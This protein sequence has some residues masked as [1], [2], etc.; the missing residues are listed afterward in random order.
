MKNYFK[1]LSFKSLALALMLIWPAIGHSIP[2][3]SDSSQIKYT[4]DSLLIVPSY[5]QE[6]DSVSLFVA[7]T[8]FSGGCG[9]K[10]SKVQVV[11]NVINVTANYKSGRLTQICHST[12][13][14]NL[15][16]FKS[17][18]YKVVFNKMNTIEFF[19][20]KKDSQPSCN[21]AFTFSFPKCKSK[22]CG[23]N[24]VKF[25]DT[26]TGKAI[27][28]LWSFGDS[29]YSHEQNPIHYY[30]SAGTYNVTLKIKTKKGCITETWQTL[31][32]GMPA[33]K[34][35]FYSIVSTCN[36]SSI[37]NNGDSIVPCN[38]NMVKF[39][40]TSFG[41]VTKC[42]WN[43]GDGTTSNEYSPIHTYPKT[44]QYWPV[45]LT[46]FTADSCSSIH[47]DS[48]VFAQSTCNANF[49]YN[50]YKDSSLNAENNVQFTDLSKGEA[51]SWHWS[52]G[53]ST[54][55]T[56]QHPSH[57]F[58][59]PGSYN[60]CLTIN[61]I[62]G[63]NSTN[64]QTLNVG[65]NPAKCFAGFYSYKLSCNDS[66]S[67]GSDSSRICGDN[68]MQFINTSSSN[69]TYSIWNFGD[70][71]FSYEMNPIHK[72]S[73]NQKVWP[74]S[75]TIYT[76]DSC[77]SFYMD[78]VIFHSECKAAFYYVIP[79]CQDSSNCIDKT[80]FFYDISDANTT[81]WQWDLGDNI[82]SN[83]QNPSHIYEKPG[84]YMVNLKIQTLNGCSS[85]TWQSINV[86]FIDSSK[87]FAN[88][89]ILTDS[90]PC[91]KCNGCTCIQLQNQ[92]SFNAISWFWKFG[93]GDSSFLPNPTHMYIQNSMDSD[94][95]ISLIIKTNSGC[96]AEMTKHINYSQ[97]SKSSLSIG[98]KELSSLITI[99]PN[100][101]INEVTLSLPSIDEGNAILKVA[102]LS[103]IVVDVQNYNLSENYNNKLRYNV[104]QLRNGHYIC[105]I[106]TK[107]SVFK[108]KFIVN[109]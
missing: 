107:K 30:Q 15:G 76:S 29:S 91:P 51:I 109:K 68:V 62:S 106:I 26:S 4:I 108:G 24:A 84:I 102:D 90:L 7:T 23:D 42:I 16:E 69:V 72:F 86:G 11:K 101:A 61:T 3:P 70:G 2:K 17:G 55:S 38:A 105:C 18:K 14:I 34:A 41:D 83:E 74:V 47:Y 53:D 54:F 96:S 46:I 66:I 80:V 19:V 8:H 52:F 87:C 63:C 95:M 88:F 32:V 103:G 31:S 82:Y 5:I 77:T 44:G 100:P 99:S 35:N 58:P 75:L 60:V 104:S 10:K 73:D 20:A 22:K 67:K 57:V 71:S 28:W 13:I 27:S 25:K 78:S 64:C 93:N 9:L 65:K 12:D 89:F 98:N 92:S 43:F 81:T 94:Y 56:D 49:T 6:G 1:K 21:A 33:C 48:I 97:N 50:L 40:N 37:Y 59:S 39:F 85:E 36:D 45:S 79:K